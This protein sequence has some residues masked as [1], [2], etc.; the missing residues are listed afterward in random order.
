MFPNCSDIVSKG[1]A[2]GLTKGSDSQPGTIFTPFVGCLVI[3]GDIW[4]FCEG[5]GRCQKHPLVKTDGV[6][7]SPLQ[8]GLLCSKYL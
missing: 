7:N 8:K 6:I 4:G 2:A 1:E 5:M 3:S